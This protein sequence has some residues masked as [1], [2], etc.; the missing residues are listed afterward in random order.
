MITN[1]II[2]LDDNVPEYMDGIIRINSVISKSKNGDEINHQELIDNTEYHSS[3]ELIQNI[4]T[5][6]NIDSTIIEILD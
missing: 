4:A 6:L 2:Y 3:N 1:V 5:R